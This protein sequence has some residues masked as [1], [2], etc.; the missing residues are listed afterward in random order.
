M[1]DYLRFIRSFPSSW[2]VSFIQLDVIGDPIKTKENWLRMLDAGVDALPVFT[3]GGDLEVLDEYY[4]HSPLVMFG[5]IVSGKGN[6]NYIRY[7]MENNQGRPVHWLG[8]SDHNF[9]KH[10]RPTSVDASSCSSVQRY[11]QFQ[12]YTG[13]GQMSMLRRQDFAKRPPESFVR[14]CLQVGFT[15][16]EIARLSKSAHWKGG[17]DYTSWDS[18]KGVASLMSH[19]HHLYRG[20]DMERSVGTIYYLAQTTTFGL[21]A[22]F[23]S[24]DFLE[25]RG[26]LQSVASSG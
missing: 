16:S 2:D 24:Y 14:S 25:E 22:L 23:R 18:G 20:L 13:G 4:R 1:N 9:I 19:V 11:G 26:R 6:K 10:Y 17:A 5:G 12:Y 7:F 8:F 15:Q 3:R 21:G